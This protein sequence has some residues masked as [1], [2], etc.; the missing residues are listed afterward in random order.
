MTWQPQTSQRI[1]EARAVLNQQIR[2]FFQAR[3]VL[4][5]ETPILNPYTVT[6]QQIE[7]IAA[8]QFGF[9]QTSPEYA[10][11]RL[12][13]FYKRDIFQLCKVFRSEE[14]GRFHHCEFSMLEW[15]RIS[16]TYQELMKE[17]EALIKY[18]FNKKDYLRSEFITY[19]NIFSEFVGINILTAD[20]ADYM[21]VCNDHDVNLHSSL[22]I[23]HFQE[24][25]LDQIILPKL[26]KNRI[27]FVYDFP[28][29]QAALAN[30]NKQGFAER[31]ECY[32]NGVELANGFQELTDADEQQSRFEEDNRKRL[33]AN[34]KAL[35][36]DDN[37]IAALEAGLPDCAGVALGV[38]RLL[39]LQQGVTHINE[40]LVFPNC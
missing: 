9:L 6:E 16:W 4:E 22:T 10:M 13:A 33:L 3:D 1:L 5:V 7:S 23:Q 21:Q 39:M 26:D 17:V 8:E 34:Q 40:V 24:L 18:V 14:Q 36:I 15:Y 25:V 35:E 2:K 30:L 27:V 38:D 19:Q 20:Q 31:F 32:L 11:K 28:K 37:F 12:L 29:E